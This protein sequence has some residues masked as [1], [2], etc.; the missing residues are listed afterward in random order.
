MQVSLSWIG[1]QAIEAGTHKE[2]VF[3]CLS[4]SKYVGPTFNCF[5]FI[6]FNNVL[7]CSQQ[8][9]PLLSIKTSFL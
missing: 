2:K 3:F 7:F 6:L 8:T 9:F 4:A 5:P 1:Q